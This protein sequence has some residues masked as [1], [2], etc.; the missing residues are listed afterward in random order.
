M[1]L[2]K[3]TD[4]FPLIKMWLEEQ[5]YKVY[6]EVKGCD[7]V[8]RKGKELVLIEIKRT[9]NMSLVHQIIRRQEVG[10]LV[11]GAICAPKAYVDKAWSNTIRLFRRLGAGLITVPAATGGVEG[12]MQHVKPAK[13]LREPLE[14]AYGKDLHGCTMDVNF[15]GPLGRVA[16]G[17][18]RRRQQE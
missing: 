10:A 13:A 14:K 11:Y 6:A 17:H 15:G 1:S 18:V 8:A 9:V 7:V 4:L 3:E 2:P 5:D 16:D 12:L